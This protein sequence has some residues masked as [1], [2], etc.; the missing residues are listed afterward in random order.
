MATCPMST[1]M[2]SR[3][4]PRSGGGWIIRAWEGAVIR[5]ARTP[6]RILKNADRRV[7]LD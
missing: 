6:G 3:D 2:C 7:G 1:P 4:K 5:E